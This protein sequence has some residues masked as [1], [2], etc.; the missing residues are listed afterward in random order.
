M[1]LP[2]AIRYGI[3]WETFWELNPKIMLIYQDEYLKKLEKED[4]NAWTLG[5]YVRTAIASCFDKKTEYPNKPFSEKQKEE[6]I[7]PE[8]KFKMWIAE[9]NNK[10]EEKEKAERQ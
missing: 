9:F 4:Y 3:P 10:F 6:S 2:A 7:S 8:E 5:L 1:W